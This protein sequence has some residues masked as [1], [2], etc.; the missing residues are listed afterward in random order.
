MKSLGYTIVPSY[1]QKDVWKSNAP[2]DV[3]FEVM[4]SWVIS[5]FI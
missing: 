2:A 4:K 3:F 5:L 1:I